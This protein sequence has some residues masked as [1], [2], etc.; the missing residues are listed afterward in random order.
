MGSVHGSK[1]L[2][3]IAFALALGAGCASSGMG[4]G[5]LPD[6]KTVAALE[7]VD[8]DGRPYRLS[9]L[10]GKVVLL[11]FWAT[12]CA[13]CLESLPLYDTWQKDLGPKGLVVVAVSVDEEDAPV[14]DFARKY[15]PNVTVLRDAK[16]DAAALLG[17][18][19]MPTAFVIGRDGGV[20]ERRP[21]FTEEEAASLRASLV[22]LLEAP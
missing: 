16:G 11:D 15:A 1:W 13:P 17:L 10:Q 12:W 2:T 18:P 20:V 3:P 14:G 6:A 9:E 22:T 21:G 19:K 7:L 8:G 5:A 4:S